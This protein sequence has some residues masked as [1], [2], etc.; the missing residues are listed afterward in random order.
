MSTSSNIKN[1]S[2]AFIQLIKSKVFSDIKETPGVKDKYADKIIEHLTS[3]LSDYEQLIT[4]NITPIFEEIEKTKKSTR[5]T[6]K[7]KKPK[8]PKAPKKPL[9]SYIFFGKD[10]RDEIKKENPTLKS[11]EIMG[12]LG[13]QWKG[14]SDK[15]KKKYTKLAE[16]DKERYNEEMKTYTP[17]QEY[18]SKLEEWKSESE[19]GSDS[20]GKKKRSSRKKKDP[21]A[22]KNPRSAYIFF[23]LEM[24]AQ[25]KEDN[26]EMTSKEI[27]SEL[28]RLWSEHK[29]DDNIEKF[30][31]MSEKDK[32]RY[33]QEMSE[34]KSDNEESDSESK[35]VPLAKK[36]SKKK[37]KKEDTSDEKEEKK[38]KSSKK[39]EKKEKTSKKKEK[40]SKK[41]EKK[42][43]TSKKKKTN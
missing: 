40:T 7:P 16:K 39:K 23:N 43:K 15:K 35:T 42:D 4:E 30:T 34:Y 33:Q 18:L 10:K 6:K 14:V 2:T 13:K 9:N 8:D 12:E 19:S 29:E 11:T 26:P 3:A 36:S 28:A 37:E 22:P 25:T 32:I 20:E 1:I 41:K 27:M 38:D 17:S 31:T 24:R 21:N 5:K